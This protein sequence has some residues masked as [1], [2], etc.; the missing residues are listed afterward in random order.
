MSIENI[1]IVH[2]PKKQESERIRI[3]ELLEQKI[4]GKI[5]IINEAKNLVKENRDLEFSEFE[6]KLKEFFD[7]VK[8]CFGNDFEKDYE[9]YQKLREK[10][11]IILSREMDI[12]EEELLLDYSLGEIEENDLSEEDKKI[13]ENSKKD[14]EIEN[15]YF[16][17][18]NEDFSFLDSLD[19]FL[20]DIKRKK[21]I[22][23]SLKS[24]YKEEGFSAIEQS[25]PEDISVLSKEE[26]EKIKIEFRGFSVNVIFTNEIFEKFF[27]KGCSGMHFTGTVFNSILETSRIK[28]TIEHEENHLLSNSFVSNVVYSKDLIESI[29]SK[30]KNF[31]ELK[32]LEAPDTILE[33]SKK[34]I[35][36]KME[37]YFSVNFSELIA[38][39]DFLP[40][41]DKIRNYL[42][43]FKLSI[44]E[45]ELFVENL[46]DKD[47]KIDF[48]SSIDKLEEKFIKRT[49]NLIDIFFIANETGFEEDAKGAM[50][51]FK[52]NNGK[53][54]RYLKNK[55][56]N[57][58]Y[59]LIKSLRTLIKET[60]ENKV[61]IRGKKSVEQ[62]LLMYIFG[63]IKKS[64]KLLGR[65]NKKNFFT[66]QELEDINNNLDT[67]KKNDPEKF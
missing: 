41:G 15:E 5:K 7:N 65:V 36:E 25:F 27:G 17:K 47:S 46:E 2:Q 18:R 34:S 40:I 59:E 30:I 49:N 19:N 22:T 61:V 21:E 57:T 20:E 48:Y 51:L 44:D 4:D 43:Q 8:K 10:I 54:E 23:E 50:L 31:N 14:E 55:V 33:N 53:I 60:E 42:Y 35:M 63:S 64:D 66:T 12:S 3:K 1:K 37:K 24:S 28:K 56:G 9:E 58:R 29:K 26:K 62:Y 11:N 13:I 52:G 38:D 67:L 32:N 16:E 6:K 39:M 45:L